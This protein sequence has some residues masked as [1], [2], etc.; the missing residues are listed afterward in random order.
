LLDLLDVKG[1][2]VSID[3]MGC[4]HKI[5]QKIVDGGGDYLLSLKGNQSTLHDDVKT[6][7]NQAKQNPIKPEMAQEYDKGHGRIECR[8]CAVITD[9][10]WLKEAHPH[11]PNLNCKG[12]CLTL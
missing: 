6:Y 2:L 4:Q 8:T 10:Q 12:C 5:A 11:W 3:A 7:F 1:A 9:V